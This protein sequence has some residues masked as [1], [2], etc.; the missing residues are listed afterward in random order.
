MFAGSLLLLLLLLLQSTSNNAW[1]GDC[2]LFN[3][4]RVAVY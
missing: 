2:D 3:S 1:K 4:L